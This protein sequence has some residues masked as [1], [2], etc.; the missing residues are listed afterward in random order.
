MAKGSSGS[1]KS[2]KSKRTVTAAAR[3]SNSMAN[4]SSRNTGSDTPF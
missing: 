2:G 3:R 1:G 4:V